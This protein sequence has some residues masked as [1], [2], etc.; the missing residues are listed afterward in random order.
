MSFKLQCHPRKQVYLIIKNRIFLNKYS[1]TANKIH[2]NISTANLNYYMYSRVEE[3]YSIQ[4]KKK[5]MA[6]KQMTGMIFPPTH[7]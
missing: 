5:V 1:E 6:K 7:I 3:V 2:L 4:N